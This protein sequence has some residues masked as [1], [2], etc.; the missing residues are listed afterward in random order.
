MDWKKLIA[1][2]AETGMT[3]TEIASQ[4]GCAQSSLNDLAKGRTVEPIYRI[5]E[6][7]VAL[8]KLRCT[9]ARAA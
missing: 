5:G 3:Q 2:L 8:H 4:V 7:L 9:K 6:R 1:E